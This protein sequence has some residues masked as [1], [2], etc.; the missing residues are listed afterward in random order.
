MSKNKG[1]GKVLFGVAVGVGLGFLFA[2]QEG[3]KTREALKVKLNELLEKLKEIDPSEVKD[4]VIAKVEELK[5]E[6]AALDKEKVLEIAKKQSEVIKKKAEDLYKYAV[7]KGT[8]VVEK[9]VDEVR[10]QAIKVAKE[11]ITKL[12]K[13]EP[14]K[15]TKK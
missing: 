8:P 15:T 7:K 12:E 9:A 4:N 5:E 14:K 13:E 1:L 6:I 2:P 10:I 3:S 11:V